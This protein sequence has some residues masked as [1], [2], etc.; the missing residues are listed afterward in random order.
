MLVEADQPGTIF[1]TISKP[2]K[3]EWMAALTLLLTRRYPLPLARLHVLVG[4]CTT[5]G[6]YY[7]AHVPVTE[8]ESQLVKFYVQASPS[9]L[10]YVSQCLVNML[11][12]FL[13]TPS[14]F[15]RMLDAQLREEE[16][17]IPAL[18]PS[19]AQYK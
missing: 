7:G 14:T 12:H 5:M 8:R 15:D 3:N 4:F 19:P 2:D 13:I 6:V 18:R 11:N 9:L 1:H 16:L 10:S 17:S